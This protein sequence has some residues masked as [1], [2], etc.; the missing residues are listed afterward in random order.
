MDHAIT[1]YLILALLSFFA[2]GLTLFT[3]FGL[4]AG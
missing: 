3:G 1:E 4:T 2:G